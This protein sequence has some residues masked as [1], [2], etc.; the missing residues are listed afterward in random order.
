MIFLDRLLSHKGGLIRL[1]TE[2]YWYGGRGYD[3]NP[4][5]ICL[6]FNAAK[7]F[8]D[9]H[10]IGGTP[11]SCST[12]NCEVRKPILAYVLLYGS[13][14]WVWIVEQDVEILVND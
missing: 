8:K 6:L 7:R 4:G 11:V 9:A 12:V 10:T 1:K 2:L 3:G 13:P 5:R 14:C